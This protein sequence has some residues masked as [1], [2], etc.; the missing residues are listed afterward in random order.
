[1]EKEFLTKDPLPF[2]KGCGHSLISQNTE[3]ALRKLN[4]NLTDVILVTDIGCHGII[5]KS[6]LTHTVHGLH[7]RSVALAS[8]ISTG[9]S[10]HGKKVIV[11]MG[12]G[13]ATIGMQHLIDSAHNNDDMTVVIHNNMLYGMT[14]GQP[15]E[16]TPKGFK[17]PTLLDGAA[18]DCYDVCE[19]V[20]AAGASYVRR[21]TGIGDF[22]DEMAEA[23]SK[24]GFS[25]IEVIEICPSYAVKANPGFKLK[26]ISQNAGLPS[27]IYIDRETPVF[28]AKLNHN[29]KSLVDVD[30]YIEQKYHVVADSPKTIM[31]AGSA[32]EGVQ[33]AVELLAKAAISCGLYSTKKGSYPVTVGIGYSASQI[34]ISP[35]EIIYT[36]FEYPDIMIITSQDGYDFASKMIKNMPE[37]SVV[38]SH[39]EI[40]I[41]NTS[42]KVMY[43]DFRNNVL[44]KNISLYAMYQFLKQHPVIPPE[45]FINAVANS[46]IGEKTDLSKLFRLN[47]QDHQ[48]SQ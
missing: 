26:E 42:A 19:I 32:G 48:D 15:S 8:G 3:K 1:M 12:D 24:K 41:E 44:S 36:G 27:K 47:N 28:E 39:S 43:T 23:F 31:F 5:D 22:S 13:S 14:G 2:C 21:I 30:N 25:L 34:I 35:E 38:Y 16:F 40:K 11:F 7:G 6:F 4:Y 45:T 29:S 9:V 20:T 46:K 37:T 10:G 17:T 33:V 18:R